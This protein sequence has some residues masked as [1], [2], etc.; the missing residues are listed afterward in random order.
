MLANTDS[1]RSQDLGKLIIITGAP[2]VAGTGRDAEP[3]MGRKRRG[4]VC[5]L[6]TSVPA[7][8]VLQSLALF[9]FLFVA[10]TVHRRPRYKLRGVPDAELMFVGLYVTTA[11]LFV[12]SIFR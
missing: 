4:D 6:R 7:G 5:A 10:V 12:R 8:L 2:V 11:L 1:Q 3:S 9:L